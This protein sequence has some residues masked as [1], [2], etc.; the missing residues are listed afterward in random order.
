MPLF[1]RDPGIHAAGFDA[2]NRRA[3]L[4][5]CLHDLD[6][7]LRQRGGRLVVRSGPVVP[8]VCAVASACGAAEVHMAAGVTAYAHRREELLRKELGVAGVALRVHDAVITAL[9]P[10][11]VTP[12]G[13]HYGVFTP[14][15]RR[16]SQQTLRTPLAAPR[17]VRV[18]GGARRAAAR[19]RGRVRHLPGL[20]PG[21]DGL[22]GPA[23]T[24]VTLRR[25]GRLRGPARRSRG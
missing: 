3:F 16:W 9:A 2:P 18:P 21:G 11:A 6:A 12:A 7:S 20:P 25:H 1:V 19:P 8:E 13:R 10:G 22:P 23:R 5:D 4:A 15:L 14:Y 24:V 17:A